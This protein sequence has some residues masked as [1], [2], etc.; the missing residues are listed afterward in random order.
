MT[1]LL[2]AFRVNETIANM[3]IKGFADI[4]DESGSS[5]MAIRLATIDLLL[6]GLNMPG[7]TLTHFLLGF[8]LQKGISKSTI[9]PQGVLGA[10]RSPFHAI[11]SFLRPLHSGEQNPSLTYSPNLVVASMKLI[12]SLCS[13]MATSEVTLRFLRSA[14]DFLCTQVSLLPF[15]GKNELVNLAMA[16]LLKTVAI[17]VKMLSQTRQRSQVVR[18]SSLLLNASDNAGQAMDSAFLS[19]LSRSQV[20]PTF[21]STL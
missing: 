4:L 1:N 7:P 11:L 12:Y 21:Y 5:T 9:Q 18:L 8:N 14:E 13:N 2:P 10:V 19:Q 17:E 6:D 3:I 16:W 15:K 20:E